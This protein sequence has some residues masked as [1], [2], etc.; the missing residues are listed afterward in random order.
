MTHLI[1]TGPLF[2]GSAIPV[3]LTIHLN[4]QPQLKS[5]RKGKGFGERVRVV[6]EKEVGKGVG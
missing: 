2:P 3:L 4:P 1:G 5:K 6:L